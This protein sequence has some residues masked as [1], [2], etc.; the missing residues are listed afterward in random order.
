MGIDHHFT[1]LISQALHSLPVLITLVVIGVV[2]AMRRGDG[3]WWKFVLGG[4]T[5]LVLSLLVSGFGIFLLNQLHSGY[6]YYWVAS[7]PSLILQ[8]IGLALLGA[9]AITGRRGQGATR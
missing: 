6:R 4:V 2:A 7:V 5:A 9:G 3:L 1:Y 8:V